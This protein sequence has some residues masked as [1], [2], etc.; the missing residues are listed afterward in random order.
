MKVLN[1]L[2]VG[3]IKGDLSLKGSFETGIR[4]GGRASPG[5][6][7][8]PICARARISCSFTNASHPSTLLRVVSLPF[9]GLRALSYID[10]SNHE[11]ES[12]Y[13]IEPLRKEELLPTMELAVCRVCLAQAKE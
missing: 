13:L 8:E 2:G 6:K 1:E 7:S 11:H 5:I 9:E 10:G 4:L 3:E 12:P